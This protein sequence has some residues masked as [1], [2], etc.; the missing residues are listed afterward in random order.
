MWQVLAGRCGA[1]VYYSY[2]L[3][4]LLMDKHISNPD[5]PELSTLLDCASGNVGLR[6]TTVEDRSDSVSTSSKVELG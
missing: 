3:L 5:K 2:S 1:V 4:Q 6:M